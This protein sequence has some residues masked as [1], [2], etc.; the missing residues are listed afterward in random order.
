MT[1]SDL[2]MKSINAQPPLIAYKRP[3]NLKD[4][5]IKAKIPPQKTRPKRVQNGMFKCNKPCSICPIVR[6]QKVVK[7]TNNDNKIELKNHHTCE[8]EM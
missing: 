2:H 4:Y 1:A 3:I 6:Q 5:L 8:I 7:A